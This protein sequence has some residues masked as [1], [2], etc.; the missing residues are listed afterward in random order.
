MR[1]H[2]GPSKSC[3]FQSLALVPRRNVFVGCV[4][5]NYSMFQ[6]SVMFKDE[7]S[8]AWAV[9]YSR[10]KLMDAEIS[11]IKTLNI[12]RWEAEPE[13]IKHVLYW[14]SFYSL[15]RFIMTSVESMWWFFPWNKQANMSRLAVCLAIFFVQ[16]AVGHLE[17]CVGYCL[18]IY[19]S[20]LCHMKMICIGHCSVF[21]ILLANIIF[22]IF[23]LYSLSLDTSPPFFLHYVSHNV[24]NRFAL[25]IKDTFPKEDAFVSKRVKEIFCLKH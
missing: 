20:I 13:Q 23:R 25:W 7:H 12:L 21:S 24:S 8:E 2:K 15:I 17:I 18:V 16:T 6:H 9:R 11:H 19:L 4:Q 5:S 10:P 3:K 1:I 22:T 14:K